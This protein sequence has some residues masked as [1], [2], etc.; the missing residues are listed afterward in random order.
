MTAEIFNDWQ[1]VWDLMNQTVKFLGLSLAWVEYYWKLGVGLVVKCVSHLSVL[2]AQSWFLKGGER[3]YQNLWFK[4]DFDK[5]PL[6]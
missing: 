5:L 3:V 4:N 1:F 6:L 2:G